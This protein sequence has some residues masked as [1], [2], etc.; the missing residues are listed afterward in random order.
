MRRR[1]CDPTGHGA[2]SR[3]L[4]LLLA[5][6]FATGFLPSAGPGCGCTA[7]RHCGCTCWLGRGT[8]ET[9]D[10][11]IESRPSCCAGAPRDGEAAAA[12]SCA[13]R[14]LPGDGSP[15]PAG[16]NAPSHERRL[17]DWALTDTPAQPVRDAARDLVPAGPL[18]HD[19]IALAPPTPPPR[20]TPAA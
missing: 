3:A 7:E 18:A 19:S 4:S 10:P 1:R 15:A 16:G 13:V 20:S 14:T 6:L 11:P 5:C 17:L 8:P 9:A 2:G 12:T